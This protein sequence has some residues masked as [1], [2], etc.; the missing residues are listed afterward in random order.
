MLIPS[1]WTEGHG[2]EGPYRATNA[3][4]QLSGA[5]NARVLARG[6]RPWLYRSCADSQV[7]LACLNPM[8]TT[9]GL[10]K[11]QETPE[12]SRKTRTHQESL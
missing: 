6:E 11:I 9:K 2:S 7:K 10:L 12:F 1:G 3:P 4:R 8:K 5:P